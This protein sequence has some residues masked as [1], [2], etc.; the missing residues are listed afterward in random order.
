[1]TIDHVRSIDRRVIVSV[2]FVVAALLLLEIAAP[3]A[4]AVIV[5]CAG[6]VA[7]RLV[8]GRATAVRLALPIADL[9]AVAI[10]YVTIVCLFRLAFAVFT[11][12]NTLGL[13]LTFA[14]GLLLGV[15]GPLVHL[16]V[17]RPRPI[18]SLG[19]SLGRLQETVMLGGALAAIQAA[20]TLRNVTTG[21]PDTWIPLLM[22][23]LVVGLFEAIF[24]RGYIVAIFEPGLG[25]TPAIAVSAGLYALYHVG[26]GM[27]PEEILFLAGLGIVYATAFA[28]TRSIF[29]LWPLLT[30]LGGFFANLRSGDIMLPLESVLGFG[31]LLVGMVAAIFL[32]SR[33]E[34]RRRV[35][36]VPI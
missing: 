4:Y 33:W 31:W 6:L 16:V 30:P 14:G 13:F 7:A 24:F 18:A 34:R 1:M 27:G 2:A 10:L 12:A 3:A 21:T 9:A 17:V 25:L 29:V 15:V 20:L 22:M 5:A 23:A 11:T 28:M 36:L 35:V 8:R 32:A 19:L 26:Y